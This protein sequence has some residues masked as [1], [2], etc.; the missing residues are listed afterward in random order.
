[1]HEQDVPAGDQS[2]VADEMAGAMCGD[3]EDQRCDIQAS[4]GE[5]CNSDSVT[6]VK[7]LEFYRHF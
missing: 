2:Q 5:R 4:D 1:M 6:A 3:G 7:L